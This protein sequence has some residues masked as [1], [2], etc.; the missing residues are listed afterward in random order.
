MPCDSNPADLIDIAQGGGVP[1]ATLLGP[2]E[3]SPALFASNAPEQIGTGVY[4]PNLLKSP[5]PWQLG[6]GPHNL[7]G[8]QLQGDDVPARVRV[9]FWHVSRFDVPSYWALLVGSNGTGGTISNVRQ[10]VR[11]VR[12]GLLAEIGQCLADAHLNNRLELVPGPPMPL[13]LEPNATEALVFEQIAPA[14]SVHDKDIFQI[15][16]A[17]IEFDTTGMT[18]LTIRSA[19]SLDGNYGVF[20]D[21]VNPVNNWSSETTYPAHVRGYWPHA[22]HNLEIPAFNCRRIAPPPNFKEVQSCANPGTKAG[23]FSNANSLNSLNATE[24]R[25]AYGANLYYKVSYFNDAPATEPTGRFYLGVRCRGTNATYF[26]AA[27]LIPPGSRRQL[28][29]IR[30]TGSY[31]RGYALTPMHRDYDSSSGSILVPPGTTTKTFRLGLA[32][33]GGSTTPVNILLGRDLI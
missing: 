30:N 3:G 9:F 11:N 6:S 32:H 14:E 23:V 12:T 28:P 18:E 7:F 31:P 21:I 10:I 5:A 16:A 1:N 27:S 25:A 8:V 19:V 2:V 4:P 22:D 13:P 15:V 24:N 33:G 29:T 20:G 17:I 26:G